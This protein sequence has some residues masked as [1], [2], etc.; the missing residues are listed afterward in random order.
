MITLSLD[1]PEPWVTNLRHASSGW[2]PGVAVAA[3]DGEADGEATIRAVL[4]GRTAA[5]TVE[6]PVPHGS[7]RAV[8]SA[9]A[10]LAPEQLTSWARRSVRHLP[11]ASRPEWPTDEEVHEVELPRDASAVRTCRRELLRLFGGSARVDDVI[12]AASE[13]AANAVQHGSG[14]TTLAV[15]LGATGVVIEVGDHDASRWPTILPLQ[16][17]TWSGRGM[18]IVNTI[19]DCWGILALPTGKV[20]WCEFVGVSAHRR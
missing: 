6:P 16:R 20:V 1:A 9:R 5:R 12:L 8:L 13:L 4:H 10:P 3:D 15:T 7:A 17:A 2:P 18:A 14:P 11:E 19:S